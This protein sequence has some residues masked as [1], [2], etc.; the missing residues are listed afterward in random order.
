MSGEPSEAEKIRL[1]RAAKLEQQA[2]QQKK[3]QED[4]QTFK[5]EQHEQPKK[6]Q[7]LPVLGD[8]SQSS[9]VK[10]K[11]RSTTKPSSPISPVSTT[12]AAKPTPPQVPAK[13]FE[14]WQNDVYSR[15]LQVTLDDFIFCVFM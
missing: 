2:Q 14:E 5:E 10:P 11:F 3:Q 4:Q 15:I 9:I 6:L 7:P 12:P 1:K 13:S 8:S